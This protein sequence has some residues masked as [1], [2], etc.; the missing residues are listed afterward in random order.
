M[1]GD[2]GSRVREQ[3]EGHSRHNNNYM[4]WLSGLGSKTE[5]CSDFISND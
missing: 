5:F 4:F 2:K 1:A 3:E